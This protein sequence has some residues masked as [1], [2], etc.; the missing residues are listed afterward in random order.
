M[1]D[2]LANATAQET[3]IGADGLACHFTMGEHTIKAVDG[4]R[5]RAERGQFVAITGPSGCGKSTLLNLLGALETPTAGTLR[6]AG[7]DVG[8]LRG[9]AA[10]HFRRTKVGFVF[11]AFNLI[12]NLSALENVLLPMEL[13]RRSGRGR[14]A[15]ARELLAQVGM[16]DRMQHRPARLSG[17]QQ[18][19]VAIARAL[20]NDPA[21]ILAD[22]PTGNLD[23]KSKRMIGELLKRLAH[24]GRT[25]VVVTHDR[26]IAQQADVAIEL[27]DGRIVTQR[28]HSQQPGEGYRRPR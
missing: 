14:E 2:H 22:E 17:G 18:Q 28:Q 7:V 24:A 25:V 15:R 1:L 4:V 3:T 27:E 13:A 20:A 21:V 9:R 5:F 23:A 12:P 26:V 6:I 8:A 16:E 19:R 11:Q 10:D